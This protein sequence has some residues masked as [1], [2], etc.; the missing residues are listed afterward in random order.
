M[1]MGLPGVGKSTLTKGLKEMLPK[2][3]TEIIE[4][5]E[6]ERKILDGKKFNP[7]IWQASRERAL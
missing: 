3:Q 5:D 2:E 4:Y 7:E 1:T 6:I